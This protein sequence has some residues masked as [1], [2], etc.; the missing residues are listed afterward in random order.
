LKAGLSR[1]KLSRILGISILTLV[2]AEQG[3]T[4]R[5]KAIIDA[6]MEIERRKQ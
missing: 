3:K 6:W 2:K 5:S 1:P 4:V